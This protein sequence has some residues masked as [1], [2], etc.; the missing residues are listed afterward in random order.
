MTT[1]IIPDDW[2]A[3]EALAVVTFVDAIRDDIWRRYGIQLMEE[4]QAQRS[5]NPEDW[6]SLEDRN[7]FG[8]NPHDCAPFP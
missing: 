6:V 5:T 7:E 8:D 4:L 3:Q 1:P 2:T